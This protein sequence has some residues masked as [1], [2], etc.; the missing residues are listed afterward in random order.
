MKPKL[1][2][3][4]PYGFSEAGRFFFYQTFIPRIEALGCEVLNP[5]AL[6]AHE[7]IART[8]DLP[9][10][11]ERRLAW[12]R[13]NREIAANNIQAIDRADGIIAVLDGADVDSGT[14]AEIGYGY[15][16]GKRIL[17]Y[18]GDFRLATDNDGGLV[19]IQV[20]YFIEHSG[21]VIA[22]TLAELLQAIQQTFLIPKGRE[23]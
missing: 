11:S 15:G 2:L 14:A 10:G 5:W 19:N 6:T 23:P 8:Q 4:G 20:Q 3:V 17:G 16:K 18:R 12:Q 13:L 7:K 21:G 1:Y 9:Y 22:T